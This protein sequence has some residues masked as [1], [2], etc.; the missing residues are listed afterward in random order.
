MF[1]SKFYR[2]EL[3]RMRK[4]SNDRGDFFIAISSI[5][6]TS[7]LM[8]YL[9]M[10]SHMNMPASHNLLKAGR[11]QFKL[12]SKMLSESKPAFFVL[13]SEA[14]LYL[15]YHW[16]KTSGT[17][18]RVPPPNFETVLGNVIQMV[19][20]VLQDDTINS[21]HDLQKAL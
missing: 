16:I 20:T 2:A 6:L 15:F 5:N 11:F 18:P 7:R 8:S 3:D 19:D 9:H 17:P 21:C 4:T 1:F 12:Y 14:F 13:Q 10:N